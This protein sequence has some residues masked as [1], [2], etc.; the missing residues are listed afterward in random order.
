MT[1]NVC[2]FCLC[3]SWVRQSNTGSNFTTVRLYVRARQP[4]FPHI[5]SKVFIPTLVPL[6]VSLFNPSFFHYLVWLAVCCGSL[7][8]LPSPSQSL[9]FQACQYSPSFVQLFTFP[10]HF[11]TQ[12]FGHTHWYNHTHTYVETH[13]HTPLDHLFSIHP[14]TLSLLLRIKLA[15]LLQ[16]GLSGGSITHVQRPG[17]TWLVSTRLLTHTIERMQHMDQD[18]WSDYKRTHGLTFISC[19]LVQIFSHFLAV[20]A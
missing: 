13:R 6:S 16:S 15:F 2:P 17:L 12:V 20:L 18:G 19:F 8:S 1:S 9:W 7:I 14:S 3:L 11:F 4:A 5:I 10:A